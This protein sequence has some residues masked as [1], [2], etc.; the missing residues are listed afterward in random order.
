MQAKKTVLLAMPPIF[1]IY[2]VIA[3]N[4][5]YHGFE[6]VEFIYEEQKFVYTSLWQRLKKL[7][8]RNLLRQ[9]EYKKEQL[10]KPYLPE[11]QQKLD[12]IQGQADYCFMIWPGVF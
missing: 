5:R 11:F 4:L 10:F 2:Q 7:F 8:Y 12:R 9:R 6:V 3:E 1:N